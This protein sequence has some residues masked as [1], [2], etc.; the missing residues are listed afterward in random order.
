MVTSTRFAERMKNGIRNSELLIFEGSAH[1]PIYQQVE[2]FNQQT[3]Q[4]LQRHTGAVA[5]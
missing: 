3:L 5:A 2:E 1:A 4:F